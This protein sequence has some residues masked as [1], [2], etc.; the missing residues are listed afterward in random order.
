[1]EKRVSEMTE[2]EK[3]AAVGTLPLHIHAQTASQKTRQ[4]AQTL[5]GRR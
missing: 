4:R 5:Y 1:M 2:E 3:I